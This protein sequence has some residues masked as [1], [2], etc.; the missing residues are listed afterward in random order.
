ML[1]PPVVLLL[2]MP[3]T[4]DPRV[5]PHELRS[6]SRPTKAQALELTLVAPAFEEEANLRPLAERVREVFGEGTRW[7]LVLVDDG[8]RDGTAR[9]IRALVAEDPRIV[10]VF[11]AE[12]QGQTA[13]TAAGIAVA[14]GRLVATLD[15]DRQNDPGDLPAMIAALGEHD[16]VVGYRRERRD[17]FVRRASSRI[18]NSIRNRLSGDSIRDTGCSLKLFRAEALEAIPLFEGMHRFLPTLLRMHGFS[19]VEHPVSHH[20]RV[21]GR[22]KYGVTNRAWRAFKDLLAVRW[23]RGRLIR[24]PLAGVE[25]REG[26][27]PEAAA[28]AGRR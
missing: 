5:L 22:S 11:F 13:A 15:A 1:A 27:R 19:V 10:G 14:R 20:P 12:N 8:S 26:A 3:A 18:A 25:R 9:V 6:R 23:M 21:A 28:A 4:P 16:A 7:E 24:L 17:G 2:A